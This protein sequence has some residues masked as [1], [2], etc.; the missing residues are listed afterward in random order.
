MKRL[1]FSVLIIILS[2][3]RLF[4]QLPESPLALPS[5]N[6]TD[7]GRYGEYP[8]SPYTG[9]VQ[10]SIPLHTVKCGIHELPITL[11]YIGGG[12]K[13]DSHPGWVGLN[14]M[15]SAGGAITREINT[16]PDEFNLH[17]S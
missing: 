14:W 7:I 16:R 9:N 11:N 1:I 15:L 3:I 8:V 17:Y 5:P 2:V 4:C 12:V 10:V 6:A 13:I